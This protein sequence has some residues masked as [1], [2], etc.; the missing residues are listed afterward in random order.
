MKKN[1]FLSFILPSDIRYWIRSARSDSLLSHFMRDMPSAEALDA[2]YR[3]SPDPWGA[4]ASYYQRQKYQTLLSFIPK[5]RFASA[6]DIG[7][8]LGIFTRSLTEIAERALGAD[9]SGVAVREAE[10]LSVNHP[11]VCFMRADLYE[12]EQSCPRKFDLVV[13]ADT[14]YYISPLGYQQ[15]ERARRT[16]ENL[17]APGGILLLANHFFFGFDRHSRQTRWL[18]NAFCSGNLRLLKERYRPFYL[19][20]ILEMRPEK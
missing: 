12:L 6:I 10:R 14:L 19:A 4:T 18:H 11:N 3:R 20:S 2:L 7:C 1:S 17:L 13:L 8:G 5:R 16:V 15:V 9:I